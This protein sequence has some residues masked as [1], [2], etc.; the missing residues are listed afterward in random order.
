LVNIQK[1]MKKQLGYF[2]LLLMALTGLQV[3]AQNDVEVRIASFGN[4]DMASVAD[5][6][7]Y[8]SLTVINKNAS[9]NT[10]LMSYE[11][12]FSNMD[13]KRNPSGTAICK[14]DTYILNAETIALLSKYLPGEDFTVKDIL[15]EVVNT[16]TGAI[17]I[18]KVEPLTL[19]ISAKSGGSTPKANV[20][21]SGKLITGKDHN[22]PVTNQKVVL[23]DQQDTE[24]Q[25]T[26]T[27]NYG[28]FK[29]SEL[30]SDKSYKIN[31]LVTDDTKI[32]DGQLY[33]AKPDGTVIK[34]FNKTKKGYVYEL[35]P[36]ELAVLARE[37]EE[38]T[39]LR[40]K[41]FG[42][43][44]DAQLTV[45]E[46][47][48]YDPNSS[49]IKQESVEKLDKIISAMA[50]NKALRLS[51]NSHTDAKGEDVYNMNLSEKRAQ[52]VMEYFILQGIEKGRLKAK[53]YGESQIKNRCKN[54]VDCS[55]VEHQ[56]NRRTEFNFTK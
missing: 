1:G 8:P 23:Q 33:A 44:A 36:A 34:T 46:N 40:I 54:G 41:A 18:V 55:E 6:L 35:L 16:K 13:K 48:Y 25:S 30:S 28:D 51:I 4:G 53:G 22:Q 27:D 37:K 21:Y 42:A 52:K 19:K 10:K 17:E 32:K 38:D 20:D 5:I 11:C 15:V 3:Q 45:I 24:L 39:E 12:V 2:L 14:N 7:S 26:V 50:G 49:E 47:V 9:G 56:L 29:F 31:V 43:S